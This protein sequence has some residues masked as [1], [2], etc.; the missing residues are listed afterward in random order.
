M[1]TPSKEE[2]TALI[3]QSPNYFDRTLKREYP[4]W[5]QDI[6]AIFTGKI[7]N[8]SVYKWLHGSD[9]GF[10]STCQKPTK[11]NGILAGFS[12]YC[13]TKCSASNSD[14]RNKRKATNLVRYGDE[15]GNVKAITDT[16]KETMKERYGVEHALASEEF[17]AKAKDTLTQNYGSEGFKHESIVSKRKSTNLRTFGVEH[18]SQNDQVKAKR[19]STTFARYGVST[20]LKCRDVIERTQALRRANTNSNI[21]ARA[22]SVGLIAL[23]N[24]YTKVSDQHAWRCSTCS[25]EFNAHVDNGSTP[26]C[27]SCNPSGS[28]G[29]SEVF[30]FVKGM[31]RSVEANNRTLIGPKELDI[32]IPGLK[33]AIEYNGLYWHSEEKVGERYHLDKTI[34]CENKGVKLIQIFESEWLTNKEL[35]KARLQAKMGLNEKIGARNCKTRRIPSSESNTFLSLNHIQGSCRSSEQ[36]GLFFQNELVAVMT[37]GKSRY[38]AKVQWELLRFASKAGVTVVG[39]ASKLLT[40]FER[41]HSPSSL[42]SYCDR[43]WNTGE[44]YRKM[45]F[46]FSHQS[47]PSYHYTNDGIILHNRVK[48]QKHKLE[49][50]LTTFD[51]QLTEAQN[52]AVNGY[53]RVWDCGTQV[54]IK[55]Y[56]SASHNS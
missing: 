55:L 7:L 54:F 27:P 21:K 22:A 1:K 30:D 45:G 47:S 24:T 37:F 33:L 15:R 25:F 23:F 35:V 32:F 38:D 41:E 3:E 4:D 46:E 51:P 26:R 16:R 56:E 19:E 20:K 9:K 31:A 5:C 29:E 28:I 42:I 43:R 52:M 48:F 14:T 2:V 44:S 39:G 17:K 40:A 53:Y 13:G 10:C 49:K 12:T 50:L 18:A 6:R 36:Y 8:E 11:F 34:A